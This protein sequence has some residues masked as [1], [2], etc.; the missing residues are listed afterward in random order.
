[1]S[2]ETTHARVT[3]RPLLSE[4]RSVSQR[5]QF[6]GLYA[7]EVLRTFRNPWVLV[8]TF[9]QPFMWLAFLRQQFQWGLAGPRAADLPHEQLYRVPAPRGP[10]HVDA[11]RRDVRIDEYDPGQTV[12]IHEANL[13]DADDEGDRLS[14]EGPRVDDP[15]ARADPGDDCGSR[16]LRRDLR[17]EP[18]HV[19]GLDPRDLPPRPGHV[20]LLPRG[21][22]LEHGLA[23]A[24]RDL[25]LHHDA[26]HVRERCAP[27]PGELPLVDAS[28][29]E[30]QSRV[31][32]RF[33]GT[34]DRRVQHGGLV[35]PRIP[36]DLRDRDA[37]CGNRDCEPLSEGRVTSP[38]LTRFETYGMPSR[39]GVSC[40]HAAPES[41]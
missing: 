40:G 7:R 2:T 25:E 19:G 16:R 33:V 14:V 26:A 5:S 3:G 32:L 34:R 29:R 24:R 35:I 31:L 10:R 12:R 18:A 36:G 39:S 20:V 22:G 30:R 13:A 4:R 15:R 1:M 17:G 9:V 27:S 11:D 23:D 37:R 8:I 41:W 38:R 28:D 21:A 6:F